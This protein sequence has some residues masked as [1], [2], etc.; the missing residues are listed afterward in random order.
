MSEG[1]DRVRRR[2]L[3]STLATLAAPGALMAGIAHGQ[4][5]KH[6]PTAR[7]PDEGKM[8]SLDGATG[9]LNTAP[10]TAPGLLGKVVLIDIWTYTCI[11]WLRTLPY[12]RSWAGKY[13]DQG[14]VTIGV[15]SPEF[16]FEKNVDN[17]KRAV[18]EMKIDFPV[19]IDSNFAIWRALRNAYWPAL[20]LVDAKGRIRYH[21]F[22][23]GEYDRSEMAIQQL[24][25]DAG[26]SGIDRKLVAVAGSGAEAAPDWMNLRSPE[27]YVGYE[28][29]E[30]FA[31]GAV[32]DKRNVYTAPVRLGL[33][34]WALSG[35]WTMKK[36]LAALNAPNGRI[37]NQFHARDLHLVMGP[38]TQGA[39]VR[40]RVTIDG[41]PPRADRGVDVD[42]AGNGTVSH[43]RLHQLIRQK[44]PIQDRR[45]EVEF[46]DA[47]VEAFSFTFG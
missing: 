22:G 11:N 7:L 46:L 15:H 39:S 27:N 41:Q 38:S 29:T 17:I 12:V 47:G 45:F 25:T 14:L 32:R 37:V 4:V 36:G 13:K 20:Y 33:N 19:A 2:A 34:Q 16:E 40:F 18:T 5:G 21:H 42:E 24:L 23:E 6:M 3:G 31:G 8:P 30:N 44:S 26:V 9:W 10:L 1:I 28:R 35:D 43:Q